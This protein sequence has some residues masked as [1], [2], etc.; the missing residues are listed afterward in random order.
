MKHVNV[1]QAK[2]DLCRRIKRAELG[3]EIIIAKAE[4]PV[5]KLEPLTKAGG[6]RRLGL[7][8]RESK[9]PGDCNAPSR[10]SVLLAFVSTK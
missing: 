6:R 1:H 10:E 7:F 9:I 2:T 3:Q 5:A 8:D 4:K